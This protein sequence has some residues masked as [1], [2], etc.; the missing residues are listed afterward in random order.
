[1]WIDSQLMICTCMIVNL[2]SVKKIFV[3]RDIFA[4]GADY[5]PAVV[6]EPG[7]I[8]KEPLGIKSDFHLGKVFL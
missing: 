7:K 6:T 1:M 5:K 3:F 4:E 2:W 8:V